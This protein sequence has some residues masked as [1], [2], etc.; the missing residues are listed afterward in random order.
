MA[1]ISVGVW[2]MFGGGFIG[3]S[4]VSSNGDFICKS[5]PMGTSSSGCTGGSWTTWDLDTHTQIY[6]G[7]IQRT[8]TTRNWYSN[9]GG[10]GHDYGENPYPCGEKGIRTVTNVVSSEPC[11]MTRVDPGPPAP[12]ATTENI[13]AVCENC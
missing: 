12:A 3:S 8:K 13:P 4:E 2:L 9:T 6:R 10:P 11:T 7:F 5:Q 1:G